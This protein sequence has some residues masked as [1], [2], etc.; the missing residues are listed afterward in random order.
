MYIES[1]EVLL[2]D[3]RDERFVSRARE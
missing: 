3:T 1:G 2:V